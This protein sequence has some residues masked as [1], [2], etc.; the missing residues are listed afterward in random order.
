MAEQGRAR[1]TQPAHSTSERSRDGLDGLAPDLD[2]AGDRLLR[3]AVSA[4]HVTALMTAIFLF[5]HADG[6]VGDLLGGL[7]SWVGIAI[8]LWLA[9]V[10]AWTTHRGLGDHEV[11]RPAADPW[12]GMWLRG[13]LWS[14]ING[15]LFLAGIAVAFGGFG[16]AGT[17]AEGEPFN[18]LAA[19]QGV[20]VF[21]AYTALGM[22]LAALV[23]AVLGLVIVTIDLVALALGRRMAGRVRVSEDR[24]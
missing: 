8:Y 4:F 17:L 6:E 15:M 12:P 13:V 14:S 3:F 20:L 24:G 1:P 2:G 10:T 19:L 5:L 7:S 23:G 22:L 9:L 16:L 21:V 11:A 18:A